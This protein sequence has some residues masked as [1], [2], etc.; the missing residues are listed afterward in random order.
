MAIA[1]S[2]ACLWRLVQALKEAFKETSLQGPLETG[3]CRT[4]RARRP[5]H[6]RDGAGLLLAGSIMKTFST[7][8]A[9]E[10]QR[11]GHRCRMPEHRLNIWQLTDP[12]AFARTAFIEGPRAGRREDV[13]RDGRLEGTSS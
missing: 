9:L 10:R 11:P 2:G 3:G 13:E 6:D 8:A 5:A 12:T 7:A 1:I 4:R